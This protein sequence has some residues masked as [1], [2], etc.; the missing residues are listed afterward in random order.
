MIIPEYI[1]NIIENNDTSEKKKIW[2][3][4]K[5]TDE[6]YISIPSINSLKFRYENLNAYLKRKSLDSLKYSKEYYQQVNNIYQNYDFILCQDFFD[7][8]IHPNEYNSIHVS[9]ETRND[10]NKICKS[11][12]ER[13]KELEEKL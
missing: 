5:Q 13:I 2:E 7:C 6:V 12:D 9:N 8:F 10:L 4:L 1:N 3:E 11:F